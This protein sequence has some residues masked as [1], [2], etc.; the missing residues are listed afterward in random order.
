MKRYLRVNLLGPGPS[1]YEKIIYRAVVSQR[2]G[3]IDLQH[4]DYD[5]LVKN[6]CW[7]DIAGELHAQ[8]KKQAT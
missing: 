6:N 5:N 8:G 4:K 1:S 2:L 7:K 3:N